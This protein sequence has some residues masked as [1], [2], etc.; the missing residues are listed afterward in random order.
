LTSNNIFTSP[1]SELEAVV[2]TSALD[3]M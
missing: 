3:D 1:Q 2:V